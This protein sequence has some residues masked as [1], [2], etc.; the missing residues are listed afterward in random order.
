VT[1]PVRGSGLGL[2]IC[3]RFINAMSGKLW[4]EKS[5]PNEGSTF[6]FYLPYTEPPI[7]VGP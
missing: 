7:G 5:V 6:S 1:T 2:Y 4:L 3:R